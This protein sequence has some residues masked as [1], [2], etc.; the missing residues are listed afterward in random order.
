M[1]KRIMAVGMLAAMVA[2]TAQG[3]AGAES[4]RTG[5]GGGGGGATG[6]IGAFVPPAGSNIGTTSAGLPR[7]GGTSSFATATGP[8][9][10]SVGGGVTVSVDAASQQAAASAITTGN[11]AAF[12]TSLGG[13][14]PGAAAQ[15]L[16]QA[17]TAL[18]S[19]MRGISSNPASATF[20]A[21]T[22][23]VNAFNAA[24]NA[25]PAGTS[26]P[27]SLVAARALIAGYYSQ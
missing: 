25:M 3:Q 6:T 9:N 5:P 8:A 1:M 17:L 16:G 2:A 4:N 20:A 27:G 13:A 10:V 11:A 19:A 24:V 14:V 23:A 26:A 15:A 21:L 12:V 7:F 22:T 18:G